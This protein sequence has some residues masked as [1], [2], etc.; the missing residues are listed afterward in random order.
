MEQR[1]FI[2]VLPR[3]LS[4]LYIPLHVTTSAGEEYSGRG[5]VHSALTGLEFASSRFREKQMFVVYV[6]LNSC[7]RDVFMSNPS[8]GCGNGEE[9]GLAC[10]RERSQGGS[11]SLSSRGHVSFSGTSLSVPSLSLTCVTRCH[12]RARPRNLHDAN[13]L[14][15]R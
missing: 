13:F 1:G 9:C 15:E 2:Q 14:A 8:G 6:C 7:S 10:N 11:P 3:F 12:S 4:D 5:I